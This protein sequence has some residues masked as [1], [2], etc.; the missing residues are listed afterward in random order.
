MTTMGSKI[1]TLQEFYFNSDKKLIVILN[2]KAYIKPKSFVE[3]FRYRAVV[4]L[5]NAG[6]IHRIKEVEA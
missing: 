1:S 2:D 5:I 4:D 3:E 6:C